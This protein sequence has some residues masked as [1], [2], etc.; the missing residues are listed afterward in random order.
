MNGSEVQDQLE[1]MIDVANAKSYTLI[2]SKDTTMGSFLSSGDKSCKVGQTI[3]V[4][5][6]VNKKS[7]IYKGLKAVSKKKTKM[8][9]RN[10]IPEALLLWYNKIKRMLSV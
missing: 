10:Y 2:V 8:A 3:N 9:V 7:Y 4:Q 6:N 5:F 1:K